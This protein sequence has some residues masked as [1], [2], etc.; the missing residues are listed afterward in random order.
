[1]NR[2]QKLWLKAL[3]SGK[4]KQGKNALNRNSH[5]CCLGV[6]CEVFK[7]HLSTIKKYETSVEYDGEFGQLPL[8]INN[9][10]RLYNVEGDIFPFSGGG[11]LKSLVDLNDRYG[12]TFSEIA[13]I[14]EENAKYY[15]KNVV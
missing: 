10:L 4:F 9:L 13:D 7:E 11:K 3:R 1:M 14:I 6:A 12:K 5:Y 2:F 15:F 8:A